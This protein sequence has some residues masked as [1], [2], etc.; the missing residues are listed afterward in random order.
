M[1]SR[2]GGR[3][4]L[5]PKLDL[6]ARAG[7][8]RNHSVARMAVLAAVAGLSY[9]PEPGTPRVMTP[10]SGVPDEALDWSDLREAFATWQVP[11]RDA[12]LQPQ[13]LQITPAA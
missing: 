12:I 10:G 9:A 2:L 13:K 5:S 1:G 8:H 3:V 6:V 7:G 11:G 4:P